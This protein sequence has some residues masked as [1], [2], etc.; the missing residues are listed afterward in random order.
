MKRY[1]DM[2]W[3]GR[4]KFVTFKKELSQWEIVSFVRNSKFRN[5]QLNIYEK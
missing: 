1:N 3:V 2:L 5:P 4:T